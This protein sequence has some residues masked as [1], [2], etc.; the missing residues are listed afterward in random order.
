MNQFQNMSHRGFGELE[1]NQI[2]S[3]MR[4][5]GVTI[6]KLSKVSGITQNRIRVMRHN[7]VSAGIESWEVFY[8]VRQAQLAK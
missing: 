7:G 4:R 8:W 1:G 2:C 3:M 5:T 6:R